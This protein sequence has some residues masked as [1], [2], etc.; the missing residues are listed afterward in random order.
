MKQFESFFAN[1]LCTCEFTFL[2]PRLQKLEEPSVALIKIR[3]IW[4]LM[5]E[6]NSSLPEKFFCDDGSMRSCVVVLP[7]KLLQTRGIC[8]QSTPMFPGFTN[9]SDVPLTVHC[10]RF[11]RHIHPN[12]A[13]ACK[14]NRQHGLSK[15]L[16]GTDNFW[17]WS[18]RCDPHSIFLLTAC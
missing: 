5:D 11:L 14:H 13:I 8:V 7:Q 17:T 9:K 16:L 15:R 1:V 12:L 2:Q 10:F 3:A 18:F 6:F 4:R